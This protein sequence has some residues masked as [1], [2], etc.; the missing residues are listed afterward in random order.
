[1]I[2]DDHG[3]TQGFRQGNLGKVGDAAVHGDQERAFVCDF[4]HG[5][6]V[7]A[8]TLLMAG[9]DPVGQ[10]S[11]FLVEKVQKDRRGADAVG[12]VVAVDQNRSAFGNG[13]S[14]EGDGLLH[15]FQKEGVAEIL[16]GGVQEAG[17]RFRRGYAAG[18]KQCVKPGGG[19]PCTAGDKLVIHVM[20]FRACGRDQ[21]FPIALDLRSKKRKE[22]L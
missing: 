17:T 15:S 21:G 1:M 11:T 12:I 14:E 6:F 9:R 13:R 5:P 3:Q 4:A 7:E 18:G 8:V 20:G 22:G 19:F 2:R 10:G 16:Q